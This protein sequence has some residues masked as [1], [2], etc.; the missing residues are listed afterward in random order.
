MC[1]ILYRL[2]SDPSS[3]IYIYIFIPAADVIIIII[4]IIYL[5]LWSVKNLNLYLLL[6]F[7]F[8]QS[9]FMYTLKRKL[10][11]FYHSLF[12]YFFSLHLYHCTNLFIFLFRNNKTRLITKEIFMYIYT[13]T[14]YLVFFTK[15]IFFNIFL[16]T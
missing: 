16:Y 10:P 3:Y 13:M 15:Y 14:K 8:I 11:S 4:I 12:F 7:F 9:I 6:L 2:A 5:L 1:Q